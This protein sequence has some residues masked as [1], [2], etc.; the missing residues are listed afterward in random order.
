MFDVGFWEMGLI[1]VVALVV[2]G[3]ERLPGL[4]RKVGL[5]VGK[6]QR[7]VASVKDEVNKEIAADQLKKHLGNQA[8]GDDEFDFFADAKKSLNEAKDALNDVAASADLK[9][10]PAKT[11]DDSDLADGIYE[12]TP[13]SVEKTKKS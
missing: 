6:A 5:Y 3:P 2:I 9:D 11:G 10:S 8:G 4:A 1:M 13:P 7:M 12:S